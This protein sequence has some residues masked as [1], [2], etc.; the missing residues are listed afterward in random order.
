MILIK[1]ALIE[2]SGLNL[3]ISHDLFRKNLSFN[4]NNIGNSTFNFNYHDELIT[5]KDITE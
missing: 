1:K 5:D 2:K 4:D 3:Q